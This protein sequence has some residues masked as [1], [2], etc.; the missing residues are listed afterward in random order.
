MKTMKGEKRKARIDPE[1]KKESEKSNRT[2][3]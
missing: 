2:E 1:P 3:N